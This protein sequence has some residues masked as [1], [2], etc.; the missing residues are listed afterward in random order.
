M[1][2]SLA[3][4]KK[5][6]KD[7]EDIIIQWATD[8]ARQACK[9]MIKQLRG[10]KLKNKKELATFFE[11]SSSMLISARETEPLLRNAMKYAKFKLK[12]WCDANWVADAFEEYLTWIEREEDIRPTIWVQLI[13]EWDNIFTHCHSSSVVQILIKANKYGKNIHVYNSETRPLYQWRKT[14]KELVEAWVPDTMVTDSSAAFF[15]D[16]LYGNEISINKVFLWSDCIKPNWATI[17]KVWSFS[18]W[19]SAWHS[20]IPL[21]IVWSLLKIDIEENIW[22]ELRDWKELWPEAPKWLNII[23][24]AFDMIPPKCITWFVTEFGVIRPENLI[25]EIKKHYP[26]MLESN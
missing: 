19:L 8:I 15:V 16:N 1:W 18:I 2:N 7:I 17:N 24:Y 14:S 10:T 20:G 5:I 23:N 25:K 4:V 22:I 21:Y 11:K 3:E 12:E 26:R 6:A 13:D 9:I